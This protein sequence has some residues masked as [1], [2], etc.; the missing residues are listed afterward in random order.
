MSVLNK[1]LAVS[2]FAAACTWAGPVSHFG[3]LVTCG[4]NICGEKTGNS[5]PVQVKG[6]S[7][8]WS[9]GLGAGFYSGSTIDWFVSNM[10][11]GVVRAAMAIKYWDEKKQNPISVTDGN[12]GFTVDFGYLSR[13]E[14]SNPVGT[15]K[16]KQKELI[17]SIID[18][19][20]A[21]DIY[22]IVDWHSHVA[23]DESSEAVAFFTEMAKTYK[24]VP[25]VIWE[26][27][28]EPVTDAGTIQR[29]AESVT[30]AI[31]NT[32][33]SNLIIV[34]SSN[35]SAKPYNQSMQGLHK[36]YS[37]IAYTLHFYAS[38]H[39]LNGD[40]GQD[41][42]N[43]V[44]NKIPIFATEWG[45]TG[46]TG[47]GNV[48]TGAS[49][50]WTNWM[51]QNKISNCNW[52]AGADK[53]SS[54]MFVSGTTMKN[55]STSA[56]TQSGKYFQS[57]MDKNPWYKNVPSS[58]ALAKNVTVTVSEGTSKTLSTELGIRGTISEVSKPSAGKVSFTG[59]SITYETASM[60]SPTQVIF[61]Y[62]VK[63]NNASVK[64]R[65]FVNI[66][67]RKPV[68]KDTTL[69]VSYKNAKKILLSKIGAVNPETETSRGLTLKSANV[70]EGS[71]I[72]KQDTI[73]F[74]PLGKPG[75]SKLTYE[76]AN[77]SGSS[78]GTLNLICENQA[79]EVYWRTK[80]A[81]LSNLEPILISLKRLRASDADGD[82]IK[83]K[84]IEKGGFPGTIEINNAGDTIIYTPE[85]NKVGTV[86][87]LVTVTDG[88]LESDPGEVLLTITGNGVSFDGQIEPPTIDPP[89]NSGKEPSDNNSSAFHKK[90]LAV[91]AAQLSVSSR[92]ISVSLSRQSNIRLQLYNVNGGKAI[93]IAEGNYI[94]GNHEFIMDE[95]LPAGM[96]MLMLRYGSQVKSLKLLKR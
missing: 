84:R 16:R 53:Q 41:A 20:V 3:K 49:D 13:D 5:V 71:V 95:N 94:A 43:A 31:R 25:N 77:T 18:A 57:Y 38:S 29:Y 90:Q 35:F 47:D 60:G 74:T 46:Y 44:A 61:D 80:I 14:S 30:R 81:N 9:T 22:V 79:P 12:Q 23:Q 66:A 58:S 28:N 7:M 8:Y 76:V 56:L 27:Y 67:N 64:G 85:P 73:I 51:D 55:I 19:A 37:N 48:D 89:D 63:Q 50:T 17:K 45:T 24:D 62:T 91:G 86:T 96:Y 10:D 36:S 33:N 65:V 78:T 1:V 72:I 54:A 82:E 83:F 21:N 39:P 26:I 4:G 93:S 2:M 70:T 32:G 15:N 59:S 92:H 11:I 88:S 52:F 42:R 34:G 6:P 68:V 87:L 40:Y 75:N 69:S